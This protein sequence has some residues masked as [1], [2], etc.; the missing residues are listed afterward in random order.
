MRIILLV[1]TSLLV[2]FP[3]FSQECYK[4]LY[5]IDGDTIKIL[6]HGKKPQ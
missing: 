1:I 6:Y 2:S 4:L 5:I 3:S